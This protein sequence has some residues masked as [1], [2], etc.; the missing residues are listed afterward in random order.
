MKMDSFSFC[1]AADDVV[2][3][4]IEKE[5]WHGTTAVEDHCHASCIAGMN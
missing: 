3:Q 1:C 5:F 2:L 4:M